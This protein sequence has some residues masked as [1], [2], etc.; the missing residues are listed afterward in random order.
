MSERFNQ[1]E[2]QPPLPRAF[3]PEVLRA[4]TIK[5]FLVVVTRYGPEQIAARI[6]WDDFQVFVRKLAKP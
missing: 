6:G 4:L 2:Q 5:E 3:R 1:M